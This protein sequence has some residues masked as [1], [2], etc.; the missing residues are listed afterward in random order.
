MKKIFFILSL[1]LLLAG[2][3]YVPKS[4]AILDKQISSRFE[5]KRWELPARIYGRPLELYVGK[6]LQKEHLQQELS[7]LQYKQTETLEKPGAYHNNGNVFTIH[8][9]NVNSPGSMQ[10]ATIVELTLENDTVISLIDQQF[11]QPLALFQLEP[12]LFAS[13]YPGDNEDRLL[14]QL[15]DT[16]PLLSK[17]LLL[18]EDK[19]FYH[20]V[21]VRP[22]AIFSCPAG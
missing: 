2:A 1:I 10:A 14:I 22:L 16:P 5:G 19:R 6:E 18:I 13:I 15:K 17:T 7:L 8:S 21:G 20:H 11:Q 12:L 9:R 3:Y 4:I